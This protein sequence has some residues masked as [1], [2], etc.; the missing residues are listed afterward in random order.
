MSLSSRREHGLVV[1]EAEKH[2][3][4]NKMHDCCSE[5]FC[6]I[7]SRL[8]LLGRAGYGVHN[9]DWIRGYLNPDGWILY[10]DQRHQSR[11][12]S[13]SLLAVIYQVFHASDG[14]N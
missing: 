6:S 7:D 1:V 2:V 8:T 13:W 10:Q 14:Q 12:H 5:G 9:C 3:S 11:L 4:F